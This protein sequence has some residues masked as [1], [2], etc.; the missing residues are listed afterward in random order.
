MLSYINKNQGLLTFMSVIAWVVFT[1]SSAS[2]DLKSSKEA[3]IKKVELLEDMS[4]SLKE[5][6][7]DH[8]E[9]QKSNDNIVIVLMK[10]SETMV[11]QTQLLKQIQRQVEAR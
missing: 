10:I 3:D 9:F 7:R 5:K 8:I 4:L 11:I 6:S 1:W 2:A